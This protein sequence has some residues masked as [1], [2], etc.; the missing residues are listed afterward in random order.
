M[1]SKVTE[2][3]RFRNNT[4]LPIMVNAWTKNIMKSVRVGPLTE[5]ILNSSVGE[6]HMD[7]MLYNEED[8]KIWKDQ[9]LQKYHIIGKFRSDPCILGNYSWMEYDDGV[10]RCVYTELLST[11]DGIKGHITLERIEDE[12]NEIM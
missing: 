7:S 9:G 5:M 11:E 12:T 4:D 6:W 8:N 2:Y 10:F 1:S 3:I